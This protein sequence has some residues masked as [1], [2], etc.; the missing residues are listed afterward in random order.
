MSDTI[1]VLDH[2]YVKLVEHWGSD[3]R[4][5]EAARM[6]TNKGFIGWPEDEKL[7][8]YLWVNKHT[9]PFEQCGLSIEVLA[10][11]M[12]FRE[13]HRHRTQSYNEMS[14]RYTQMPDIHYIPDAGRV[15]KQ[16]TTN[17]QGT[18]NEELPPHIVESFLER[19]EKEQKL[20]YENYEWAL[21]NGIAREVARIN[22]PIS[23]YSKM[24]ASANLL[25]WLKFLK[26]RMASNA[27]WEIQQYANAVATF[28]Q[29]SFPRTYDLFNTNQG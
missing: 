20:I 25:N 28:I 8:K 24:V 1:K 14:G 12:V 16:S 5:I 2:G 21:A 22:T 29:E 18:A 7:L 4:I 17:K 9:S 15:R 11:I 3:S 26:L 6:S 27:Q 13:W 19:I 10:P 23:R